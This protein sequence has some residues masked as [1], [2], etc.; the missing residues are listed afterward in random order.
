MP[1]KVL[2][3]MPADVIGRPVK[4]EGR[5]VGWSST[6]IA[7][8]LVFLSFFAGDSVESSSSERLIDFE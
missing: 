4:V 2:V 1:G 6:A 7:R 3:G 8:F 5:G